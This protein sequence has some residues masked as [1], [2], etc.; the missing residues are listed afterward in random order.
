M[1]TIDRHGGSTLTKEEL[2]RVEAKTGLRLPPALAKLLTS[3]PLV[4]LNL[5]LDDEQDESGLGA[6]LRWMTAEEMIDEAKNVYPGIA[7][8][9][10]GFLPVGICLEG[11]GD[12]YFIRLKDGAVVRI[13]H[14]AVDEEELDAGR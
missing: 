4:G 7:A 9:P 3:T 11:S 5:V 8:V 13:P 1:K 10:L 2:R 14:D 12:P 6:D